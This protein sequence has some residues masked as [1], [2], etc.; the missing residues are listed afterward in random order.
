MP[1]V[2]TA[3]D[4]QNQARPC[5]TVWALLLITWDTRANIFILIHRSS[6]I[7]QQAAESHCVCT[8]SDQVHWPLNILSCLLLR[9]AFTV[10]PLPDCVY[11]KYAVETVGRLFVVR[12]AAQHRPVRIILNITGNI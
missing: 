10:S 9:E 7:R 2:S 4:P 12:E 3:A 8:V 11:Y 1:R 6:Q 5:A